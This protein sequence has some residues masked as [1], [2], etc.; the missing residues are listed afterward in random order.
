MNP[1]S[2]EQVHCLVEHV[3]QEAESLGMHTHEVSRDVAHNGR[4]PTGCR[5][6]WVGDQRGHSV[7]RELDFGHDCDV[8]SARVLDNLADVLLGIE[9][10]PVQMAVAILR[11]ERRVGRN[12]LGVMSG[13]I[14]RDLG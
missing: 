9:P 14:L 12:L 6:L 1:A 10:A 7:A 5:N 4:R 8:K 3:P 2:W 11:T 13:K